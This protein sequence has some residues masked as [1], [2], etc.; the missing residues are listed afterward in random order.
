[1]LPADFPDSITDFGRFSV[2]WLAIFPQI[3]LIQPLINV[4]LKVDF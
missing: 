2:G 4:D 3:S 1:M